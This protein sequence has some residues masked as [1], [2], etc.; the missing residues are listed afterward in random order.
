MT[1]A[2]MTV[3]FRVSSL[4]PQQASFCDGSKDTKLLHPLRPRLEITTPSLPLQ[5]IVK[6]RDNMSPDSEGMD[7][8]VCI[9]GPL[10]PMVLLSVISATCD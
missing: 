4:I 5:W 1:L 2:G 9:N 6:G 8:D 3:L 7:M 10:L